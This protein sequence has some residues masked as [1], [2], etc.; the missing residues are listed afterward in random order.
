MASRLRKKQDLTVRPIEAPIMPRFHVRESIPILMIATTIAGRAIGLVALRDRRL[1]RDARVGRPEA[2]RAA[3]AHSGPLANDHPE[4]PR[5]AELVEVP[6]PLVP[7]ESDWRI[8]PALGDLATSGQCVFAA[9]D[10]RSGSIK[11]V[12]S[13]VG[14]AAMAVQFVHEVLKSL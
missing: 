4:P 10:V 14:E 12:A 8:F 11:R 5:L 13:D 1:A 6:V 7:R 9:G 2:Q 3:T